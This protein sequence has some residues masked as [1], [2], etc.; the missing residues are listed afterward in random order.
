VEVVSKLKMITYKGQ[1]YKVVIC[2]PAGREKIEGAMEKMK[3]PETEMKGGV[4]Y[5]CGRAYNQALDDLLSSLDT[6]DRVEPDTNDPSQFPADG[7]DM[8]DYK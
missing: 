6:T 4:D 1:T 7:N 3:L 8:L 5:M 2:T